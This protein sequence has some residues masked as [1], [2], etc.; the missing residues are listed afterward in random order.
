MLT[1]SRRS[2]EDVLNLSEFAKDKEANELLVVQSY[3][4][5]VSDSYKATYYKTSWF[6]IFR[7]LK[8]MK[9]IKPNAKWIL[10]NYGIEQ[11]TEAVAEI[12]KIE[13]TKKKVAEN[14]MQNQ[15]VEKS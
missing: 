6:N 11:I 14:Q 1:L 8:H 2:A 15:S 7:K 13:N 12:N 9:F 3:A 10:K 5:M 4:Y